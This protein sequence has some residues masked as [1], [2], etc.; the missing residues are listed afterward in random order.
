MLVTLPI[1][2]KLEISSFDISVFNLLIRTDKSFYCYFL[3]RPKLLS[4]MKEH[5]ICC[6]CNIPYIKNHAI[7]FP[8]KCELCEKFF[9]INCMY[10]ICD[11]CHNEFTCFHCGCIYKLTGRFAKQILCKKHI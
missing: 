9:C 2:I 7:Y 6:S 10:L 8:N 5:F 3:E 1:E 11:T 4:I